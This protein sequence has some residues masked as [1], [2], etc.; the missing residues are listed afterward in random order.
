[1]NWP[2]SFNGS[3][4]IRAKPPND[5]ANERIDQFNRMPRQYS[6][7]KLPQKERSFAPE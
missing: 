3:T 4:R 6:E 7:L 1:M 2:S 5:I